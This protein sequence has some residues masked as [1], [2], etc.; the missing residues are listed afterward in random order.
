MKEVRFYGS[1]RRLAVTGEESLTKAAIAEGNYAQRFPNFGAERRE[2]PLTA[3][4]L[5]CENPIHTREK[6][7]CVLVV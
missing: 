5:I 6:I 3:F 1:G 7:K 4:V 2:A